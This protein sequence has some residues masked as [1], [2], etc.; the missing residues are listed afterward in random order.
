MLRLFLERILGQDIF[1]K[2]LPS[3]L[4]T[5]RAGRLGRDPDLR[6]ADDTYLD[7]TAFVRHILGRDSMLRPHIETV[8]LQHI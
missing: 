7:N 5:F 8:F 6:C 4:R 3:V 2:T 1:L